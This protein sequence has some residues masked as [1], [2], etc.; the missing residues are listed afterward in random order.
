MQDIG[1]PKEMHQVGAGVSMH[2]RAGCNHSQAEGTRA[3]RG[4]ARREGIPSGLEETCALF[5][6]DVCVTRVLGTS[7]NPN[8]RARP[9]LARARI[10]HSS[11]VD[12]S[13]R[14]LTTTASQLAS[15]C[16]RYPG[17]HATTFEVCPYRLAVNSACEA[18]RAD[19]N[20]A[21]WPATPWP[22]FPFHS[23][24]VTPPWSSDFLAQFWPSSWH[25]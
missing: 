24:K 22:G 4:R 17:G 12:S 2:T 14:V 18:R 5:G 7:I 21:G 13:H 15:A 1:I 25:G 8:L 23:S 3:T 9:A 10:E 11:T 16:D 6:R 20:F 19:A